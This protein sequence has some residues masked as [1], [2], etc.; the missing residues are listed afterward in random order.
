M[1]IRFFAETGAT[2]VGPIALEYMRSL[3]RIAPV[4]LITVTG[5]LAP[6]WRIFERSLATPMTGPMLANV[7]CTD[8][9]HWC[10]RFKLRMPDKDPL[11]ELL[12]GRDRESAAGVTTTRSEVASGTVELY[13]D[14]VT[15]VLIATSIY[16]TDD[17]RTTCNRYE[18]V[19]TPKRDIADVLRT[20]TRLPFVMPTPITDHLAMRAALRAT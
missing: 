3:I 17:Q 7:V 15:N 5:E 18:V 1:F 6:A 2:G 14:G 9:E 12:S 11:E 10:R 19:V 4:R 20:E 13:T 16:R 8:P